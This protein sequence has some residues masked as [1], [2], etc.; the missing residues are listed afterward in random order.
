MARSWYFYD[1]SGHRMEMA[2]RAAGE[3]A[4]WEKAQKSAYEDLARWQARKKAVAA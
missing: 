3:K 2:V 4:V 1:P